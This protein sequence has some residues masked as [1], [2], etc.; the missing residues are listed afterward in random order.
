M[1]QGLADQGTQRTTRKRA[2]NCSTNDTLLCST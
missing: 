2:H 1:G